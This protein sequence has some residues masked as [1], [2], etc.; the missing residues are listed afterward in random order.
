MNRTISF[1]IDG[2]EDPADAIATLLLR[3]PAEP[4]GNSITFDQEKPSRPGGPGDVYTAAWRLASRGGWGVSFRPVRGDAD[5]TRYY[6]NPLD[7]ARAI[8]EQEHNEHSTDR[9]GTPG[10]DTGCAGLI[11]RPEGGD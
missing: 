10:G 3:L 8:I 11:P 6:R 4:P 1:I 7:A 2:V 5:R 9:D